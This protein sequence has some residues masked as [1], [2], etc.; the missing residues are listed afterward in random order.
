MGHNGFDTL[1]IQT[2]AFAVY[3]AEF[4]TKIFHFFSPAPPI[5][6]NKPFQIPQR[7]GQIR[8]R[9]KW[10]RKQSYSAPWHD[11]SDLLGR[12]DRY[13]F[14]YIPSVAFPPFWVEMKFMLIS[15]LSLSTAARRSVEKGFW[16]FSWRS[17][18]SQLAL[19][20]GLQNYFVC[21]PKCEPKG[22][23]DFRISKDCL[24][25]LLLVRVSYNLRYDM[26]ENMW[27]RLRDSRPVAHEI[28]T[29]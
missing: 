11:V 24:I 14:D 4:V 27:A 7:N 25:V 21:T 8:N 5:P 9:K 23:H 1:G 13:T 29:T 12:P 22:L 20:A 26:K 3:K 10:R 6:H 19:G 17:I 28:H 2:G 15:R 16:L 18:T